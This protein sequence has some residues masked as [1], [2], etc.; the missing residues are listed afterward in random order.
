MALLLGRL[1]LL[2]VHKLLDDGG[3]RLGGQLAEGVVGVR[4][5]PQLTQHL[6]RE[7]AGALPFAWTQGKPSPIMP[8]SM[9]ANGLT[10][11]ICM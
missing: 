3:L 2:L 8:G 10:V 11:M 4:V 7:A 5:H 9:Q 6:G 1:L